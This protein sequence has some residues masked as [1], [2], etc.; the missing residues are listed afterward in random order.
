MKFDEF[1]EEMNKQIK[2]LQIKLNEEQMK[3]FYN[4]MN[5]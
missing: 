4:F 2:S 5:F 1:K 3:A